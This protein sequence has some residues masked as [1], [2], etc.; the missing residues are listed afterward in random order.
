MVGV[1]GGKLA[2]YQSKWLELLTQFPE[3]ISR[4][5][6]GI[7]IAFSDDA[8]S[9]LCHRLELRGNNK[10]SDLLQAL[11]KLRRAVTVVCFWFPNQMGP[12]SNHRPQEVEPL[13]R[14]TIIQIGDTV[15]YHSGSPASG[16]VHQDRIKG[17]LQSYLGP[18]KHQ[19]IL[20]ICYSW[21][22]F[23]FPGLPFGYS[24]APREFTKTLASLV[25]L[26]RTRGIR[27]HAYL[28]DWII[29][30]YNPDI[31][32]QHTQ[33]TIRLLQSLGWTINWKK[34]ILEP[35]RILDI[36]GLHFNLEQAIVSP[37]NSFIEALTSVVSRLSAS[38]VMSA[39]KVASTNSRIS[40]YAPFI[41]H[42]H[43]QLPFLQFWIKTWPFQHSQPWDSQI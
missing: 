12:S 43:R 25:Q 23:Q 33:E 14:G 41:Y 40:H 1:G 22:Y 24:T 9:L 32:V 20:P 18:S 11:K 42:G 15:L 13:P 28:D 27:V 4:V 26:L 8:P 10:I 30:A 37:L 39:C 19:E 21:K 16:M 31:C 35:S 5:Y 6:Q 36:L 38:T 29:W 34:S 17:R 3:I 7:L 2:R